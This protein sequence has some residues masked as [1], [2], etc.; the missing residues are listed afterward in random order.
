MQLQQRQ[1]FRVSSVL[2]TSLSCFYTPGSTIQDLPWRMSNRS[3]SWAIREYN[4]AQRSAP[5]SSNA[6]V[7]ACTPEASANAGPL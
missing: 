2:L 6:D 5:L 3:Q 4:T 7:H 1:E